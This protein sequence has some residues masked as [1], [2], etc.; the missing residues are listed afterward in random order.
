MLSSPFSPFPEGPNIDGCVEE[1]QVRETSVLKHDMVQNMKYCYV[2]RNVY[3]HVWLFWRELKCQGTLNSRWFF[4]GKT[5][6]QRWMFPKDLTKSCRQPAVAQATRLSFSCTRSRRPWRRS[7][8]DAETGRDGG[9]AGARALQ[10]EPWWTPKQLLWWVRGSR[11]GANPILKMMHQLWQSSTSTRWD[12][13]TSCCWLPGFD[14]AVPQ[15][16]ASSCFFQPFF[17]GGLPYCAGLSWMCFSGWYFLISHFWIVHFFSCLCTGLYQNSCKS[18]Q[19]SLHLQVSPA[20]IPFRYLPCNRVDVSAAWLTAGQFHRCCRA[21]VDLRW[22]HPRT[23][24]GSSLWLQLF[25]SSGRKQWRIALRNDLRESH[26]VTW[27]SFDK[28]SLYT[29]YKCC[30]VL[31]TR[32]YHVVLYEMS[33]S[34]ECIQLNAWCL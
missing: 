7:G 31:L 12:L 13:P 34:D 23:M 21:P 17:G 27:I 19:T 16:A 4:G 18:D 32:S 30:F 9:S 25:H 5:H 28:W 10:P 33:K 3:R 22:C 6:R 20:G 2:F 15:D 14:S 26:H 24:A 1:T 29:Y 11:A 8:E